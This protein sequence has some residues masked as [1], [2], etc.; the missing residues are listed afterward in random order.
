MPFHPATGP[1]FRLASF[2]LNHFSL[3]AKL[4]HSPNQRMGL[5]SRLLNRS[6]SAPASNDAGGKG[7]ADELASL[8][9][10]AKQHFQMG[11]LDEARRS[12]QRVLQNQPR[13]PQSLYML[14]GIAI[15]DGDADSAIDLVRRAIESE[16]TNADFHFS[17]GSL[18][19][20]LGRPADALPHYQEAVR[21]RPDFPDWCRHLSTALQA[22]DRNT[23]VATEVCGPIGSKPPDAQAQFD[24]GTVL[25]QQGRLREAES[26]FQDAARLAPEAAGAHV[27]LAI[28]RRDQ[29]RPVDA[30]APAREGVRTAPDMPEAWFVLGGALSRQARHE[31]AAECFERAIG[32]RPDYDAAWDSLL[33]SMNYSDKWSS[34]EIYE[35]HLRWGRRF[36]QVAPGSIDRSRCGDGHRIRIGYVSS[37]YR[38]HPIAYFMEGPLKHHDR[39]RVEVFCYHTDGRMDAMT[40]RLKDLADRWRSMVIPSE[41]ALEKVIREDEIDILVELSGHTDGNQLRLL[42]RR[43]APVQVTYLGYP[44][45]TG[46]ASIDYRITDAQ[47]DPPGESDSL[48]VEKIIRLPET[49]LCYTPPLGSPEPYV[50]PSERKGYVTFGSF[51]NFAKLSPTTIALWG[52]ILTAMPGSRLLVKTYGLQ[53][54][55]LQA[56]LLQRFE[57]V[58]VGAERITV[59]APTATHSDHMAAYSEVD[60]ALDTFP[61]NGTTTTIDALWMGVPVVT[62]EG[63]RHASRVGSSIL[64]CVGLG[65]FIT[66]SEGAYVEAAT[67]LATNPVKLQELRSCLRA[68][69]AAS[70]LT[71]GA[72]FTVRL[73]QAYSRMWATATGIRP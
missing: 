71:D 64:S 41:D 50:R 8:V 11:R 49:F 18:L 62:L 48:H 67:R 53:D 2:L 38:Q 65:E 16:P 23:K 36:P 27:N 10:Q 26:A 59:G 56:L 6:Q 51:N 70:V 24:L 5:L 3:I 47:A 42:A 66:R 40:A 54:P 60:V 68:K 28:V 29:N 58:G 12:F 30:E 20:S 34:R 37:D 1:G 73:E 52:K 25:Q 9:S 69:L 55:G 39:R 72:A 21:L 43:L 44:N 19:S 33:F 63:N 13:H 35:A 45:S 22:A 31:E 4:P 7:G 61:Y 14:G 17:L 46:L 57:H 15:S 32:L